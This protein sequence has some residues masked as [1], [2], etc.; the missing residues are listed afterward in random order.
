MRRRRRIAAVEN[1]LEGLLDQP[2]LVPAPQ[3]IAPPGLAH[4]RALGSLGV[5]AVV[6]QVIIEDKAGAAAFAG[7]GYIGREMGGW[8]ADHLGWV[9]GLEHFISEAIG[10][11][12]VGW[13]ARRLYRWLRRFAAPLRPDAQPMH[14]ARDPAP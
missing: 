2:R 4:A 3:V 11:V 8:V 13:G 10:G 14:E 5:P 12:A 6:Q 1:L 9:S 7:G